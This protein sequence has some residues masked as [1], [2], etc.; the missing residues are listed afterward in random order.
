MLTPDIERAHALVDIAALLKKADIIRARHLRDMEIHVTG[1]DNDKPGEI[2][3][4]RPST[5]C[6]HVRLEQKA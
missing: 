6:E 3:T 2:T 5:F 4:V 1:F